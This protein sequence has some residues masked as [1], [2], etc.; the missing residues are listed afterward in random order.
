MT[1]R[2]QP[3]GLHGIALLH[4]A[5]RNRSTAFS[6]AE[7]D[8]LGLTGLLPEGVESEDRRPGPASPPCWSRR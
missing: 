4:D 6:H 3:E 2:P 5:R 7:R 8:E 1:G